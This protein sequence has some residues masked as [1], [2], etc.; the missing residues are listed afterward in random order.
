MTPVKT[1]YANAAISSSP[2]MLQDIHR[3]EKNIAIYRRDITSLSDDIR[4]LNDRD[5]EF[6]ASGNS[7]DILELLNDFFKVQLSTSSAL[8]EDISEQL[9]LFKSISKADSFRLYLASVSTDMCR[10]FHTDINDLRLLCTY[11]GPG[12]LW[13]P[14]AIVDYRALQS[15]EDKNFV[16]D[17]QQIQQAESGDIVLLKGALYPDSNPIL[18]RSPSIKAAGKKRLLLRIDTNEFL[19]FLS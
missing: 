7:E 2:N 17:P 4:L 8:L 12:T 19:N 14:D 16:L 9:S 18:H 10:K 1:A 11:A 6:R 5:I 13:V 15:K 3:K